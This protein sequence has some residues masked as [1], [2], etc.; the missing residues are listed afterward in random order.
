MSME[1]DKTFECKEA[2][3]ISVEDLRD[4]FMTMIGSAA[5]GGTSEDSMTEEHFLH[6]GTAMTTETRGIIIENTIEVTTEEISGETIE[7]GMVDQE[8]IGMMDQ[9]DTGVVVV[10]STMSQIGIDVK[11]SMLHNSYEDLGLLF[12][13]AGQ[14]PHKP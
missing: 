7:I 12:Q 14:T 11:W 13:E 8:G 9:E 2:V 4:L 10:G 6:P 1:V 5:Q 3:K